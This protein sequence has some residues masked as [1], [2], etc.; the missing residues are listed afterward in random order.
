M[1][2]TTINIQ[3]NTKDLLEKKKLV[4]RESFNDLIKRLIKQ[5]NTLEK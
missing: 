5:H 4:K 1:E 2:K 3:I